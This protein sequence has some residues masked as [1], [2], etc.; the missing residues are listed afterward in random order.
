MAKKEKRKSSVSK[1]IVLLALLCL[2]GFFA[3]NVAHEVTQMFALKSSISDALSKQDKLA[4]EKTNLK[5]DKKNLEN[6]E[7]LLRYARGKYLVT[8][9]DGEQVFTLPEK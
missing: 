8:K 1:K 9:E 4:K 5:K 6:P 7:Y 2:S 3:I